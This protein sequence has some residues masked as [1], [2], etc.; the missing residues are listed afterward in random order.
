MIVD[1]D[2]AENDSLLFHE[3]RVN[4]EAFEGLILS[5]KSVFLWLLRAAVYECAI[6]LTGRLARAMYN[7]D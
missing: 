3:E 7:S 6:A 5:L 2:G 4:K 1:T